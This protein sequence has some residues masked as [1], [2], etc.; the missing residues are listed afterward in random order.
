MPEN[1]IAKFDYMT[2]LID[3]EMVLHGVRWSAP[4]YSDW[5][6]NVDKFKGILE[7]L[8]DTRKEE[9]IDYFDLSSSEVAELFPND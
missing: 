2:S 8:R 9:L 3:D 1:L 7:D 5:V 4:T 6:Y